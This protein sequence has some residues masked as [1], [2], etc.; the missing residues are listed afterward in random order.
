M[1]Q[2]IIAAIAGLVFT[3]LA[4]VMFVV[5]EVHDMGFPAGLGATWSVNLNFEDS[6]L[7]DS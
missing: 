3:L 6:G 2:K 4:L 7:S 5:A 1:C